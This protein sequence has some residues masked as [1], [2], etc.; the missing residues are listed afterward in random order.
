MTLRAEI[1][2]AIRELQARLDDVNREIA[3]LETRTRCAHRT[4]R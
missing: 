1:R 4:Y 2:K 3:A